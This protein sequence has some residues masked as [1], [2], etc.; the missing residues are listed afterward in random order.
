[1][2]TLKDK[3]HKSDFDFIETLTKVNTNIKDEDVSPDYKLLFSLMYSGTHAEKIPNLIKLFNMIDSDVTKI[4][5][6]KKLSISIIKNKKIDN[7]CIS[8]INQDILDFMINKDILY[9]FVSNRFKYSLFTKIFMDYTSPKDT[10]F[11]ITDNNIDFFVKRNIGLK[12]KLK[13]FLEAQYFPNKY[14]L[15]D[16]SVYKNYTEYLSHQYD[17][18][19]DLSV[20]NRETLV[21]SA[22][23]L[24]LLVLSSLYNVYI[25]NMDT[26][27]LFRNL[28]YE[29]VSSIYNIN[30]ISKECQL[31]KIAIEKLTNGS[32]FK[33]IL[34]RY[35]LIPYN[36]YNLE[37]M[38]GDLINFLP[39]LTYS[40]KST[41]N[42]EISEKILLLLNSQRLNIHYKVK[43]INDSYMGIFKNSENQRKLVD[44]YIEIEKY[45]ENSGFYDK[46]KTRSTIINILT[47]LFDSN[48]YQSLDE[49]D[50]YNFLTLFISDLNEILTTIQKY[51]LSC[52]NIDKKN[53]EYIPYISTAAKYTNELCNYYKFIRMLFNVDGFRTKYTNKICEIDYTITNSLFTSRLYNDISDVD[54]CDI[55]VN[56]MSDTLDQEL[57]V[58][59]ESFYLDLEDKIETNTMEYLSKNDNMYNKEVLL[60][61]I[62]IFGYYWIKKNNDGVSVK[63][64]ITRFYEKIDRLMLER[65]SSIEK[66]SEEIP[67]QYLDPIMNTILTNPVELPSSKTIVEKEVIVNHLVFSQTD[68][69]NRDSLTVDILN[70]H[71]SE[72]DVK[73]RI[74]EFLEEFKEWKNKHRI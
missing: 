23:D 4:A 31:I 27:K 65:Q 28:K 53:L 25:G 34:N 58:F 21:K 36:E 56:V 66:Y 42:D 60:K 13:R 62:D 49:N 57:K 7:A 18:S 64:I 41:T 63:S 72:D 32:I 1:M 51:L 68:P 47:K 20:E 9:R 55:G 17:N 30:N 2:D 40:Q 61:T 19:V 59:F 11:N 16:I 43:L 24:V 70:K 39:F 6:C 15:N 29:L 37:T 33:N 67:M 5:I 69:F 50:C 3:I 54:E 73:K 26:I 38:S 12:I 52:K 48:V 22:N 35:I 10:T 45:N 44:L 71:N 46:L 74:A 14:N 8:D